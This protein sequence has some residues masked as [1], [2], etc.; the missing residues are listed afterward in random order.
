MES[1]AV[2]LPAQTAVGSVT[3]T[4][5]DLGRA[6]AFYE[7]VLGMRR[8]EREDGAVTLR[9]ADG[10]ALLTLVP[11]ATAAPLHPR[12]P[13]LYHFAL[14]LPTRPDLAAMLL[15]IARAR[16]PLHGA[17]DHL[18]SEALYLADPEG[19]GIELY[20]DRPR[21]DWSR[22]SGG[23]LR[24]GSLPLDLEDLATGGDGQLAAALPGGTV[25]GHV[26][27]Q[28]ADLAAARAFYVDAL[29]LDL[30]AQWPGALFVS[31]GGYHHHLGLNV[32]HSRG[33]APMAG[34]AAGLRAFELRL[35][36]P[37]AVA[38]ALERLRRAGWR[39]DGSLVR[40]PSGNALR[41]L[42]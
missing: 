4:V 18:V 19:N 12:R 17:A 29:G 26:H 3:L 31:A 14:L 30:M 41:L 28:V 40:D 35:G 20:R 37:D 42:A 5:R 1:T 9:G 27:L 39:A 36:S 23:A 21:T 38:A 13:G 25:V 15:R 2:P 33:A 8:A 7:S 11:D 16:W 24:M 6:L 32:W 22:D 10:A 34:R